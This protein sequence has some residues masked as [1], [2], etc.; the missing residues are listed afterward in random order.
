MY[1]GT[2]D[3]VVVSSCSTASI[4]YCILYF[5]DMFI[6][7]YLRVPDQ[8]GDNISSIFCCQDVPFWSGTLDYY[9]LHCGISYSVVMILVTY[10]IQAG[11]F[12]HL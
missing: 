2:L 5:D 3:F 1:C 7:V 11:L 6:V 9:N 12:V 4:C 10:T 8:S